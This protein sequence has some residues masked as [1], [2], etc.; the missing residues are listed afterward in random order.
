MHILFVSSEFHPHAKSGGLADAVASLAVALVSRGHRVTVVLP[1]YSSV[2]A[3]DT[4]DLGIPLG[5]PLGFREE[6]TGIRRGLHAGVELYWLVHEG[7]FGRP[8]IYGPSPSQAY[9]DNLRRFSLLSLGALQL[10]R[11]MGWTPDIV[12]AHDWP[13]ALA[14][15]FH[16]LRARN[17]STATVFSIHNFGYQGWYPW[18]QGVHTGLT[19]QELTEC[20][21]LSHGELNLVRGAL[22]T[23]Q[24]IVAVS[25]RYAREIQTVEHGFGLHEETRNRG[26]HLVGILNGIDLDEW[27]PGSDH[28]LGAHYSAADMSGK[29]QCKRMLQREFNLPANDTV[30][31][32]GMVTRLTEQKGIGALFGPGHGS[33]YRICSELPV[34]FVFMGS[35][36]EWCQEEIGTLS[37]RLRNFAAIIGYDHALAHR[38]EAGSDFFLMPSTY[39]PCGLNQMYAMRYG[40]IP[41]VNPTGGLADTVDETTGFLMSEYSPDGIFRAVRDAVTVYMHDRERLSGMR[42]SGMARDF[43]WDRSAALYEN[44]YRSARSGTDRG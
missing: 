26:A 1:F 8:G 40:T 43:G 34:Q 37:S 23:A 27:D 6:W 12:H 17:D 41:I 31:V 18:D 21:V 33:L 35:G 24:R 25:P 39:E 3:E 29:Q 19:T 10:I 20:G 30:P 4:E 7:L 2:P 9:H 14:P 16:H 5:V 13:S 36:E 42:I 22:R 11:A 15:V 32:I 28:F 38:V 44:L